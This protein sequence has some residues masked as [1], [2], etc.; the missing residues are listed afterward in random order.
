MEELEQIKKFLKDNKLIL[1]LYVLFIVLS[2]SIVYLYIKPKEEKV[3]PL[4]EKE[5][6][7][8]DTKEETVYVD[9]KGAVVNPG[10]YEVLLGK[11]VKDVIELAGGLL[12]NADT[13]VNN[14][15]LKV[16]DEMNIV[17]Y[18]KDEIANYLKVKEDESKKLKICDDEYIKNDSCLPAIENSSSKISIN[19][20]TK[21][22]L[23]S[24]PGI[25]EAKA[26]DIIEYR[27]NESFVT[28]ED[29]KKVPG[30]GDALYVKIK[31]NII[32]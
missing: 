1:I 31:E 28:I 19:N 16:K 11:R 6:L 12:G 7:K 17:I 10:T 32:P 5:D 13:S 23:M 25:G 2:V 4:S 27:K 30:I 15:S 3:M 21:E 29:I 24:L 18:T 26:L 22:E 20:A 14:L 8:E 9:I